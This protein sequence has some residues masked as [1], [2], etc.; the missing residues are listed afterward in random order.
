[1]PTLPLYFV[2]LSYPLDSTSETRVDG[3]NWINKETK[4]YLFVKE[5]GKNQDHPHFH[6]ICMMDASLAKSKRLIARKV[7]LNPV[8]VKIVGPLTKIKEKYYIGYLHKET[9]KQV[10]V[11]RY[12]KDQINEGITFY[13]ENAWL[14]DLRHKMN[15]AELA[16]VLS[17]YM[18]RTGKGMTQFWMD[19]QLETN[20]I[21][22]VEELSIRMYKQKKKQ[23]ELLLQ[24]EDLTINKYLR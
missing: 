5:Y 21:N 14:K 2:T 12:T 6:A 10:I 24:K 7:K 15:V 9:K 16:D 22:A 3:R 4:P 13:Q 18:I 19:Y 20:Q 17:D 8:C 23:N 1:M 11:N